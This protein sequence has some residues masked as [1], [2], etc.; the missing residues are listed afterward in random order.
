MNILLTNDDGISAN[1]LLKLAEVLRSRGEHNVFVLAPDSNRSGVSHGFTLLRNPLKLA[2][3]DR[4]TYSCPG[5]PVDCAMLPILGG[6]PCKPDVVIS[7]INHGANLGT[8]I[9]YSGTAAAARQAA[10][11]GVPGIALSL[12]G[13]KDFYWDMAAN[14]AADHLDEF[15][16]LWKEDVFI[17]VNIPN[18]PKGPSGQVQTWPAVKDYHDR[19]EFMKD[20]HGKDWVFFLSGKETVAPEAGSDYDAISKNLV[21]ISPVCVYPVVRRDLCPGVPDYASAGKR[22]FQRSSQ[23]KA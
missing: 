12:D 1:G 11:L 4:D 23:W 6:R 9:I 2:E 5:K 13:R 21:S 17:N 7:G 14:Y 8:D 15:I 18:N 22:N 20:P 19:I 10:L 3:I 16:A